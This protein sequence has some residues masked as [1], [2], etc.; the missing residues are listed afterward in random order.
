MSVS[1]LSAAKYIGELSDW[2]KTNL[3]LQK[4]LY[5][6]HMIHLGEKDVPLIKE[7]FEAWVF[8]PVVPELYH[9]AKVFGSEPVQNIFKDAPSL[10][11]ESPEAKTLSSIYVWARDFSA[12][13]LFAIAHWSEGAWMKRYSRATPNKVIQDEDILNEFNKRVKRAK[14]T[15]EEDR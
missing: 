1:V 14:K 15:S 3:E 12:S 4:I 8:G 9:R 5:I 11:K 2:S 7:S 13:K 6:A 10:E